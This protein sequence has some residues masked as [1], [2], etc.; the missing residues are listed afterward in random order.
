MDKMLL[1]AM[2]MSLATA[3]MHNT[4]LAEPAQAL[5]CEAL[6]GTRQVLQEN[7]QA[8]LIFGEMH[9]TQE[10]PRAFAEV[11]CEATRQ[12]PVIVGIEHPDSN[13]AAIQ[14]YVDS[15]G[16]PADETELIAEV[17]D[18]AGYGLSSKAILALFQRLQSLRQAGADIQIA[19]FRNGQMGPGGDQGPYE[20]GLAQS[21]MRAHD[22]RPDAR[23]VVLVGNL[24]ARLTKQDGF[25][26]RPGFA[27]MAMHLPGD[28][29]L[30]FNLHYSGGT[31]SNCT[32]QGC[33]ARAFK[34]APSDT[35]LRLSLD[36]SWPNYD[37][38]W[39][40]GEISSAQ[41]IGSKED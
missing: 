1:A 32:D 24:H 30:T 25:G 37:G 35:S 16:T 29:R 18:G 33:G 19:A 41:P 11:V 36:A 38:V 12:G 34:A 3:C 13:R 5:I 15:S 9:G 2:V 21:L 39:F 6:P 28:E 31:A 22:T 17:F 40:V 8:F 26:D 23:I 20:V 4:P 27:P 10:A 7:P 14:A